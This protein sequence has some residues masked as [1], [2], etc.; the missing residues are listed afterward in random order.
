MAYVL[1]D[2]NY[3]PQLIA[4]DMNELNL[5]NSRWKVWQIKKLD[6]C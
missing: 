5:R 1:F 6:I 4:K 2:L 3:I